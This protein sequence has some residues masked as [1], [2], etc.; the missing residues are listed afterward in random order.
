MKNLKKIGCINAAI[1]AT[2]LD[3][4]GKV[5]GFCIDTPNCIAYAMTQNKDVFKSVAHY[6]MF[7]NSIHYR[8]DLQDRFSWIL[9]D[10]DIHEKNINWI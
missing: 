7:G 5:L 10:K 9:K 4:R 3:V 6:Q 2:L 8:K 1:Q